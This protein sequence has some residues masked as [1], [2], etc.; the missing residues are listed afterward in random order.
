MIS[1]KEL[2]AGDGY[3][4]LLKGVVADSEQI[5]GASA[6]TAYYTEAG[7]P[8][9]RWLGSGLAGLN[10]GHGL[11][12][13]AQV[14]EKQMERLY[15]TGSDPV[16]GEP[17]GRRYRTP[18]PLEE[19]IAARVE[20]LPEEMPAGE[21]EAMVERIE[22]EERARKVSRP[23]SGFDVTF[24]PPKSVSVLW[25]L[26][27]HGVREQIYEA[28]RAAL[29]DTIA[30][31]EREVAKT[32]I[33]TDG[34]AQA[35][36]AGVL[37]A[38][39]DHW[40]SRAGDPQLHTHVVI[41]NRVQ[42]PDGK[43]RT[44]DSRGSMF[45]ATVAM[46]ELYDTLLADHI[47]AR[48]GAGWRTRGTPVKT[49]NTAWEIDGVSDELIAAFSTRAN[50]I[51]QETDRLITDYRR[52][53][54]RS[55]RDTVKLR[56]RQIATL[57]TRPVKE[58]RTLSD[59]TQD[60]RDRAAV[61]L[62]NTPDEPVQR[63]IRTA[64]SPEQEPVLLRVDDLAAAGEL[65][66][67][68]RAAYVELAT[69]RTTWKTWNVRA[70]A[71][72]ASMRHRMVTTEER[73]RL[74]DTIT[75]RVVAM[76]VDL[77]PD[78]AASTPARF[79][80]A[81]GTS[82]F[83]RTHAGLFTSAEALA[84]EDRLLT[85][86][87]TRTGAVVGSETV[88][89]VVT[90]ASVEGHFLTDDQA[91]AVRDITSSARS[92][93]VL[94][95]PAGAG[96]TTTLAALRTAWELDH[97]EASVIG[98]APSAAAADVL[99]ESLGIEADT[100]AK[101]LHHAA[102]GDE[103]RREIDH[104]TTV[105][106]GL[107][108]GDPAWFA[109]LARTSDLGERA[110]AWSAS[111]GAD[112]PDTLAGADARD[113]VAGRL[114]RL[115]ADAQR[116]SFRPGQLVIVDEASLAGT[117][118]VD[119]LATRAHAAGAKVLMVGDWAQLASVDAGGAFGML[120][121]DRGEGLAPELT[122]VRR[123][124]EAWERRASVQLRLGDTAALDAYSTHGRLLGG[125]AEDMLDAAYTAWSADEQAGRVS[126]LIAGDTATVTELNQRA[127]ADRLTAGLVDEH[128]VTLHD[129]TV[130]GAGDRVITRNNQR[131]LTAGSGWVKNGDTWHVQQVH[132]DGALTVRRSAG[133]G[134]ITLPAAY[135]TEHV[136]LAYATTAHRAQGAT[137]DTAH[138]VVTGPSMTREV[139]YVA[140]TRAR[141][142]NHAYVATDTTEDERHL[143]DDAA[144]TARSVLT[145]VLLRQGAELSAGE[146]AHAEA[147]RAR[148][149]GQLA[150]EYD[151]LHR[152]AAADRHTT[153]LASCGIDPEA[154]ENSEHLV[155]F[156]GAVRRAD[157]YGLDPDA[158]LPK[159]AAAQ[160]IDPEQDPAR[161][162]AARLAR[163]TDHAMQSTPG[164]LQHQRR[165][166]AGLVPVAL[167]ITD[168][169][170]QRALT[171][172]EALL[173]D[174]ARV[175]AERA[176][177]EQ[178][179]WLRHLGPQ[180][181]DHTA[182]AQWQRCVQVVAAYRE[183]HDITDST[184]PAGDPGSSWTQRHDHRHATH[185][186]TAARRLAGFGDAGRPVEQP[187]QRSPGADRTL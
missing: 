116:W 91:D 34:V 94:V 129:G 131:R 181:T 15:R 9:G 114:Q 49:K 92:V 102:Q 135:V 97:G 41:A 28:H 79:T 156:S 36:T 109:E 104:L 4:Y 7:N 134:T 147:E 140:M 175:L 165:L 3:R 176:V 61:V 57:A 164:G 82:M 55:P 32:R 154:V 76:S 123:F 62:G 166:A 179:P 132:R 24:S 113:A 39:F 18:R 130:A 148:S 46:S 127:R 142:A 184:T 100:T 178:A 150:A 144:P 137:V 106:R 56:L 173:E 119:D 71:A 14:S 45:P 17:L 167:G 169:D 105:L 139:L 162:L 64:T 78:V 2:H 180:P 29:T 168:P 124:R 95:G 187:H 146:T 31:L 51:E 86:A 174:R 11:E 8:P 25:A 186:V 13:G 43:W 98:L 117:L 26:S 53:H 101:W 33:G 185:A 5:P 73:E 120:V 138:A 90:A 172:R 103:D 145:T 182:A 153:Q 93:D 12:A 67:L 158:A 161:V 68:A 22:A 121:R 77:T 88:E 1:I 110:A 44:L 122:G 151:T 72:R 111:V 87:R 58:I 19:R 21:R 149:I 20:A 118:A 171:E 107:E 126:L 159:L 27:D 63:A 16:T 38:A 42:G 75:Q 157:T 10:D 66:E 85:S 54:G 65:E 74:I 52:R 136:E 6:V 35:D 112:Q 183:R 155:A 141:Q 163:W 125:A 96:K 70:A 37:A 143:H 83:T 89:R 59:M 115:Q 133:A 60:W 50:D 47:T 30:T 128:S 170:M 152:A 84:A 108:A 177:S 69:E 48:V 160:P 23:V 80:R 81:D 40:D 99:G